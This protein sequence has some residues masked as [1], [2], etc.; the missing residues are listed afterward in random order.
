MDRQINFHG[1]AP[2]GLLRNDRYTNPRSS[3]GNLL[4]SLDQPLVD[5]RRRAGGEGRFLPLPTGRGAGG[6]GN[7][8]PRPTNLRSVPGAG[9]GVQAT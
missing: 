3:E 5:A 7:L 8:L 2:R 6:E 9:Q 1:K 4:P